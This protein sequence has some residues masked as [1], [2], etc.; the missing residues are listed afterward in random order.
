MKTVTTIMTLVS[1]ICLLYPVSGQ[2]ADTSASVLANIQHTNA[3]NQFANRLYLLH[4]HQTS[5]YKTFT[6]ESTGG[7]PGNSDF[8]REVKFYDS[9][10]QL[11]ISRVLWE[12]KNPDQIHEIEVFIY[13]DTGKL[14]RDYLAAFIPGGRNA[15]IQ[16][17]INF[18]YQNDELKSFR[19]FDASGQK[20]YEL[21]EGKFF[22]KPLTISL[23]DND[24]ASHDSDITQLVESQEYQ[25]C[26]GHTIAT[27]GDYINPLY[28]MSL[29]AELLQKAEMQELDTP[30]SLETKIK[31]LTEA[32]NKNTT[33]AKLYSE[34]GMSYHKLQ[35]FEKAVDD[36][37]KAIALDNSLD[38][39]YFGRGLAYGRMQAFEKGIADLTVYIQRNPNSSVAY[40]KRG[41]RRI[42]AGEYKLA[43]ADLKKA[44]S[45]DPKN[46]EA[47]DDM[48]V[49]DARKGHYKK[50]LEH[51]KKVVD[52][53][54]TYS[55]GF[56][57]LAMTQHILAD[58]H[59]ALVSINKALELSPND[60][61]SLL[62]KGEIM[63]KLGMDK[64]AKAIIDRAEFLPEGG[65]QER[66]SLQ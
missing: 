30:D 43:E 18:H 55:K 53:D 41:V 28:D 34:R 1:W 27:L 37:D 22:N 19:Q 56:H 10:S 4:L 39:A 36:F 51:F 61:T 26:F 16:T 23:D 50:A 40:T 8:Y 65:W 7:Y 63:L 21:C 48:G 14:K 11:L 45:L 32:I 66:F 60:K 59:H 17:L 47:H 5:Q 64:D 49:M 12:I 52:L 44:I 29:S 42:W 25:A 20:I 3:W 9:K 58:Y 6:K 46:A 31:Q 35:M 24:F 57:N 2:T 54:P 33:S 62:L 13:D 15:P 38:D